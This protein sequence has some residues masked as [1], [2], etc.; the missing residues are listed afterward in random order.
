MH[1]VEELL[2]K[3]RVAAGFPVAQAGQ[4]RALGGR[5]AQGVGQHGADMRFVQ[6][7]EH[8]GRQA[9]TVLQQRVAHRHQ[10]MQRIDLVVAVGADDQ[11]VVTAVLAQQQR[12]HAQGG[13]IGP[14][15][16]VKEQHQR[17]RARGEHRDE[18][19]EHPVEPHAHLLGGQAGHRFAGADVSADVSANN[20]R[21]LGNQFD[22]QREMG[23]QGAA[24]L[25]GPQAQQ[26]LRFAQQLAQHA[27]EGFD[28]RGIRDVAPVLVEFARQEAA[29]PS[30]NRLVHLVDDG[31]LADAGKACH[32]QHLRAAGRAAPERGQQ[33]GNDALAAMQGLPDQET[34]TRLKQAGARR[35]RA[36]RRHARRANRAARLQVAPQAMQALV[37]L[38]RIF[39]QQPLHDRKQA[40]G[41]PGERGMRPVRALRDV[42][43]HQR[44]RVVRGERRLP[45]EQFVQGRAQRVIIG[46]V[47]DAPVHPAGLL[48]RHVAQRAFERAGMDGALG[49]L[50]QFAGDA[51]V[52]QLQQAPL[53][54]PHQVG[55]I[56][57]LVD[58]TPA[59]H[60]V[61]RRAQLQGDVEKVVQRQGWLR[62][63]P[64][65]TSGQAR[66]QHQVERDA[67]NV[68]RDHGP[69]PV[70][71]AQCER[72][73]HAGMLAAARDRV[74]AL[75]LADVLKRGEF[76]LDDLDDQ[77]CLAAQRAGTHDAR[78]GTDVQLF[79]NLVVKKGVHGFF[80][81]C[82][83]KPDRSNCPVVR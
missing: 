3:K 83:A 28:Q 60:R 76:L 53:A 74:R 49:F 64:R 27:L 1:R 75:E 30:D 61:E 68:F 43:M 6:R 2:E 56:D 50:G 65:C 58:H 19:R 21:Q 20:E 67:T 32:Q 59:V 40:R 8:Q 29:A 9:R 37:T 79:N 72:A 45:A 39:L 12:D 41:Q 48:R 66:A 57:V 69:A 46:A 42:A 17:M 33:R 18:A 73:Q 35:Q 5:H 31:R 14:L 38:L 10:R 16:V 70:L 15:Q 52:D 25:L 44:H 77:G 7:V 34:A 11:Q 23:A 78:A 47:V 13:R 81:G 36:A 55:R 22:H 62:R 63:R 71:L 4:G 80:C 82:R 51:E 26:R 54:V 24:Q